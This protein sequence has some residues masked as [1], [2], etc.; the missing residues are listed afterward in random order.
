LAERLYIIPYSRD[1]RKRHYHKTNRGR[2]MNFVVQLEVEVGGEW[3]PAVRYDC[4]HS[5]V[6]RDCYNLSGEQRKEE[7]DLSYEEA[8][9]FGDE[10]IDE[11]WERYQT[12]FLH[13]G[14]P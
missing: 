10:D 2:V 13:G 8:L 11:N 3:K 4:T 7:L 14:Y 5:F 12:I 9:T 1:A 6:H